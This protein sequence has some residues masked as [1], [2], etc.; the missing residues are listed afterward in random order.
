MGAYLGRNIK[1]QRETA[2]LRCAPLAGRAV[3]G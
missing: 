1:W 3:L 2:N